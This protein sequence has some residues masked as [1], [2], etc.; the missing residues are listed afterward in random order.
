MSRVEFAARVLGAM[1]DA[2]TNDPGRRLLIDYAD[3]PAAVWQRVAPHFG[4]ETDAAAIDR[5]I[6]ESRFY[7]KDPS[8]AGL[9]RRRSRASPGDR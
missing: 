6:E 4:L 9:H 3:L 2:A 7:S 1:L 5:M 8:I